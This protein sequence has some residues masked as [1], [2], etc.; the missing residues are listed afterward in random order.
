MGRPSNTEQR[1]A[2][3]VDALLSVMAREGYERATIAAIA[4]EAG[5]TSGLLHY[6]FAHK[7]EILVALVERLVARRD[8]RFASR[9]EAASVSARAR[10]HAFIDA[11]VELGSDADPRAVG[12]WVV[13]GAEAMR[14]AEVQALYEAALD[15]SM[16]RLR[17]LVG[18]CLRELGA[19]SR[20]ASPI[21]ATIVS[22]IEG[23]YRISVGAPAVLPKGFASK[24]LRRMADGL[25][26]G[27]MR[28]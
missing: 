14:Q 11:H 22:A 19:P 27:S 16:T 6:H 21:A 7:Q 12:A 2:Q 9:L 23:A 4:R 20:E 10:L 18:A 25:I 15:A 3:I 24:A 5:L 13:V 28:D 8:A 1:R 17:T 26:E